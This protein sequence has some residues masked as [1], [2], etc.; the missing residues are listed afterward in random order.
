MLQQVTH[1]IKNVALSFIVQLHASLTYRLK[2]NHVTFSNNRCIHRYV[3][4]LMRT[5]PND[6]RKRCQNL[7]SK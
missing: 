5:N 7:V 3:L 6:M 1:S 2:H 4:T